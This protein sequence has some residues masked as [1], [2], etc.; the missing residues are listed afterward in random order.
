MKAFALTVAISA[1]IA[2]A[3]SSPALASPPP[4]QETQN[5]QPAP[6]PVVDDGGIPMDQLIEQAST[7]EDHRRLLLRCSGPPPKM[8]KPVATNETK[9]APATPAG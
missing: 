2:V 1:L 9:E 8:P 4:A 3:L 5:A 7:Q 6:A